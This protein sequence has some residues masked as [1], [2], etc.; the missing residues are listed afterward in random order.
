M[1]D[2]IWVLR[3]LEGL[4]LVVGAAIAYNSFVAYRRTRR[5]SLLYLGLGF[6]LVSVAAAVAGVLYEFLSQDLLTAW[7]ASAGF[8]SAGFLVIL[9][10]IV[11]PSE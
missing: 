8:D 6:F 3:G 10:S 11:R 2:L 7:I 5:R 4:V 1:T 9:Y